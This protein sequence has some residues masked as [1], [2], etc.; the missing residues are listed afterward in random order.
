MREIDSYRALL[1]AKREEILRKSHQR[2]DIRI[3]ESSEQIEA[4]QLAGERDVA[5]QALEHQSKILMQV[6]AALQRIDDG[7]YGICIECEEQ[8]SPKRLVAVPWAAFCL[9]C[10]ELRDV[11]EAADA[12][13]P[14]MAA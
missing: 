2:E 14:I 5:I 13:D 9:R 12:S 11:Q 3:V 10:Q 4:V 1:T 6:D 7:E 8:I